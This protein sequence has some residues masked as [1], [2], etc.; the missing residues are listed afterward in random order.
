[1]AELSISFYNLKLPIEL[2]FR[3]ILSFLRFAFA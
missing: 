3:V 2:S 1:L